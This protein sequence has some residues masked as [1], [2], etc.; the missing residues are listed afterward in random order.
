LKASVI[1]T[2]VLGLSICGQALAE[3]SA[4]ARSARGRYYLDAQTIRETPKGRMAFYLLD[5]KQPDVDGKRSY[6]F[7][8]EFDCDRGRQRFMRAEYFDGPMGE[9]PAVI[10]DDPSRGFSTPKPGTAMRRQANP[11]RVRAPCLRT[12]REVAA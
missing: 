8:Y 2:L 10:D 11:I 12:D 1:T 4:V 3:W 9:G 5:L 6:R 7:L